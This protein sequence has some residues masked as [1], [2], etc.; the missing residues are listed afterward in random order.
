MGRVETWGGDTPQ[1]V[2]ARDYEKNTKGDGVK[3]G[4]DLSTGGLQ[5]EGKKGRAEKGNRTI[6]LPKNRP[7]K[8][9]QVGERGVGFFCCP[10]GAG[11][12]DVPRSVAEGGVKHII[13]PLGAKTSLGGGG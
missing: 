12:A 9:T 7:E 8:L 3:E 1:R 5:R 6:G 13:F 11:L 10:H 2:R 4:P